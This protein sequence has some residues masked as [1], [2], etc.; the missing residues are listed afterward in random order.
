MTGAALRGPPFILVHRREIASRKVA[1]KL[2]SLPGSLAEKERAGEE[3]VD[4]G[5]GE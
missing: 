4:A 5:E 3:P 1:I 2:I